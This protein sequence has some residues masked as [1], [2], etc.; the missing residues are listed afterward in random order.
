MD[1]QHL[2]ALAHVP[3]LSS[4][5][6][7]R[8]ASRFVDMAAIEICRLMALDE[9]AHRRASEVLTLPCAIQL[10]VFRRSVANQNQRIE[11]SELL[12]ARCQFLLA[13]FA[14]SVERRRIGVAEPAHC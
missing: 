3:A 6:G 10:A 5:K 1:V 4:A 2:A 8:L 13:V 7:F 11:P 12:Q 14:G 9:F